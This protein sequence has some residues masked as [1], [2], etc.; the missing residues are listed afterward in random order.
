M[1][2]G[3]TMGIPC[4]EIEII[5]V[6]QHNFRSLFAPQRATVPNDQV[7]PCYHTI[8]VTDRSGGFRTWWAADGGTAHRSCYY[9]RRWGR[10]NSW[11]ESPLVT[12]TEMEQ[13]LRRREAHVRAGKPSLAIPFINKPRVATGAL[14]RELIARAPFSRQG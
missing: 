6:V 8:R 13:A 1:A 10:G 12:I 5:E 4:L 7:R 3:E 2:S 11:E 9:F 14:L